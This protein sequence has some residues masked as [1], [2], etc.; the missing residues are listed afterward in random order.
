VGSASV[1]AGGLLFMLSQPLAGLCGGD[2]LRGVWDD[3][4]RARVMT[5]L[6]DSGAAEVVAAIDEYAA[7]L[8][9]LQA[10]RCQAEAAVSQWIDTCLVDRRT[11]LADLALALGEVPA[12]LHPG[13]RAAVD[14][15]PALADCA[16]R[17]E[18]S[19][20]VSEAAADI[21]ARVWEQRMAIAPAFQPRAATRAL[22][23]LPIPGQV[24]FMSEEEREQLLDWRT[25]LE[26]RFASSVRLLHTS[27][28]SEAPEE[29]GPLPGLGRI[30]GFKPQPIRGYDP[31]P[32][33]TKL[34]EE[35]T[36]AGFADLAA[37][38]WVL[39]AELL[40]AR[41]HTDRQRKQLWTEAG[42]ALERLPAAHPLRRTLQRDLA[43]LRLTHARHV[44][45]AGACAGEG[46]DLV[47]CDELFAATK[48][49]AAI[50]ATDGA[51]PIDHELL[52]RAHEHAGDVKATAAAR[53]RA[54]SVVL[55]ER[56]LGYL[57]FSAAAVAPDGPTP[58]ASIHCDLEA[59]A[60]AID[61]AFIAGLQPDPS[62]LFAGVRH[63]PSV[64]DGQYRGHK[65]Y[66]IRPGNPVKLLGF[67]NG[68]LITEIDGAPVDEATFMTRIKDML[69]RGDGTL[70]FERK[71][72]QMSRRI[73]IR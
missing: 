21:R 36:G 32:A 37:R 56:T 10:E 35:A 70:A 53:A 66:G 52:A 6:A 41:P 73:S 42:Q 57:D 5:V 27:A 72:A 26:S 17:P 61:R 16:A 22:L 1:L 34:G 46:A 43:Y 31:V 13:A 15:L 71:G 45:A 30:F 49:L 64:Q 25:V 67:K 65:L 20:L 62:A 51:T 4:Q 23:V 7:G 55:D 47:A 40:E 19:A 60:C 39:G 58:E 11:A 29:N 54:G 28:T 33:L 9:R 2:D 44:T 48:S 63:M 68:D 8:Q 24:G 12:A 59:T 14:M 18:Y 38:A 69:V 50:A 3:E